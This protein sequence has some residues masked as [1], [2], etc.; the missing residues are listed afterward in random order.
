MLNFNGNIGSFEDL[1]PDS[2]SED[3]LPTGWLQEVNDDGSVCFIKCDLLSNL[4]GF[5][6]TQTYVVVF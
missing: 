4:D 5:N 6:V 1:A 2:D 3:E